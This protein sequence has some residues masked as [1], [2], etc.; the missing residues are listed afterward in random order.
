MYFAHRKCKLCIIYF[1][2]LDVDKSRMIINRYKIEK[3][4]GLAIE[5]LQNIVI[6]N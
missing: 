2:H 3:A 1:R 4:G 5:I 6:I